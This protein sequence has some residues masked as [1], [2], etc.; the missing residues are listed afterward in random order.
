MAQHTKKLLG[1]KFIGENFMKYNIT[2][3]TGLLVHEMHGG[4]KKGEIEYCSWVSKYDAHYAAEFDESTI[5]MWVTII[6]KITGT[7]CK[8]IQASHKSNN[9]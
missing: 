8:S 5:E 2:N 4:V 1:F 3:G 7:E 6:S 9:F